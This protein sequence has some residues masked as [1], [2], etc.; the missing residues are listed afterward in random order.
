M[1]QQK[2]RKEVRSQF[3]V[4]AMLRTGSG[5]H[6][7]EREPPPSIA[8]GLDEWKDDDEVTPIPFYDEGEEE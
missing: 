2:I 5:K 6:K 3:A 7:V 8:D 4:P 1:A